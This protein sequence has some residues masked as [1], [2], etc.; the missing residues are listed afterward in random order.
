M[1]IFG[2]KDAPVNIRDRLGEIVE[3][4]IQ[5]HVD[6][7]PVGSQGNFD[8]MVPGVL[9]EKAQQY[10]SIRYHVVLVCLPKHG[11]DAYESWETVFPEAMEK[12]PPRF[13][14]VHRNRWMENE[15]DMVIAYMV[16]DWGGAAKM[17]EYAEKKGKLIVKI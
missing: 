6:V 9:R 17:A 14:I 2:H 1:H 5:E 16:H 4:A 10:P 13:A 8:R 12:V 11:T 15:A 3:H 7:F